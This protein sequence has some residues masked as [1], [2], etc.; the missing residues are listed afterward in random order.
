MNCQELKYNHLQPICSTPCLSG[1]LKSAPDGTGALYF[2][3]EIYFKCQMS[4]A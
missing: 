3:R 1:K 4:L 2:L